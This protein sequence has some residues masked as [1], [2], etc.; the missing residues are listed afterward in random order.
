MFPMAYVKTNILFF[1]QAMGCSFESDENSKLNT[2]IGT[3]CKT[4]LIIYI[5]HT[6]YSSLIIIGWNAQCNLIDFVL[7]QN[8]FNSL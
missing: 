5:F 3:Y 7:V 8:I 6:V 2:Y 4:V 1:L